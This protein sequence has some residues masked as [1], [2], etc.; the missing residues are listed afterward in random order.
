MVMISIIILAQLRRESCLCIKDAHLGAHGTTA[1]K[2]ACRKM[3]EDRKKS[4]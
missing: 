4:A 2:D 1:Q 3:I